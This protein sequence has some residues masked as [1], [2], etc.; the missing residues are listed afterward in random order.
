MDS[1][2][3]IPNFGCGVPALKNLR[4]EIT[5]AAE[6]RRAMS[7]KLADRFVN[8]LAAFLNLFE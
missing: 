2:G 4:F 1:V 7:A 6:I 3:D 5:V 8:S